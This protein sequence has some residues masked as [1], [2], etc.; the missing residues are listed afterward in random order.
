M[1]TETAPVQDTR[2]ATPTQTTRPSAP[3]AARRRRFAPR[4]AAWAMTSALARLVWLVVAIVDAILALDFVFRLIGAQDEGFVHAVFV[5]GS[6]LAS[7]FNGI[8]AS[9]AHQF[10][11]ALTWSDLVALVL[12]TVAGWLVVRLV[13]AFSSRPKLFV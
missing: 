13:R 4:H 12:C 2:G 8:F 6:T 11:Y 10:P 1:A 5:V 9:V 3:V 7:P